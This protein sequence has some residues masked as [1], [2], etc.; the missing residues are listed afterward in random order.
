MVF[1]LI[2]GLII[3]GV[4]AFPPLAEMKLTSEAEECSRRRTTIEQQSIVPTSHRVCPRD[5]IPYIFELSPED[6]VVVR[7]PNGHDRKP[8]PLHEWVNIRK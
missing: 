7:C 1:R 6:A 8:L 3:L 5:N 2:T 4:V